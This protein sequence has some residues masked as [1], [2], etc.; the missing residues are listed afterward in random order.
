[1][2]WVGRFAVVPVLSVG[3]LGLT[4]C[5]QAKKPP[6]VYECDAGDSAAGPTPETT[7]AAAAA[8]PLAPDEAGEE[9]KAA[10]A[11][12][13]VHTADGRVPL[14]MVERT[15]AGPEITTVPVA[16]DAEAEAV[17]EDAAA[18]GD[19]VTVEP[20]SIV[21]ADADP[22][23]PLFSKQYA[24]NRLRFVE[25]WATY[26][27]N[28]TGSGSGGGRVVA[29]LDSGVQSTHADL[30]GKLHLPGATFGGYGHPTQDVFGHGT[31]VAGIIAAATN[32]EKGIAGAAPAA[33]ILPVRVLD[34]QGRGFSSHV[35]QAIRW[36]ADRAHVINLS[37]GGPT[38]SDAL[39][40]AV[41]YAVSGR[42]VPVISASGNSG[43]CGAGAFPAAYGEVLAVGAVDSANRWAGF[44][45]T[46]PY[47]N[48]V[49][50]GVGIWSTTIGSQYGSASGT[51]FATPYVAAAAAIVRARHPSLGAIHV[52]NRLIGTATDLG[53]P[54]WDPHFGWGL[55][56]VRAAAA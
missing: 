25:T 26:P 36:A 16:S 55:I 22:D 40:Q 4:A 35:A 10:V 17:A 29:V 18:G 13:E 8:E 52:Y 2:R 7:P 49:A 20:D 38:P 9:A 11:E 3:L 31:R 23:D 45:T 50:P 51:S 42:G 41:Q 56:N 32:N 15:P 24:L 6:P 28:F 46:A 43:K 21:T 30:Q 12:A 53:S 47:V 39:H 37:L 19:L 14:V 44:S 54:G 34:N 48:V 1:M 5:Q 27:P 33:K